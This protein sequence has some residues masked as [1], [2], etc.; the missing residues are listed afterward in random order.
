MCGRGVEAEPAADRVGCQSERREV[1]RRDV[2]RDAEPLSGLG[3]RSVEPP[4]KPECFVVRGEKPCEAALLQPGLERDASEVA[5]AVLRPGEVAPKGGSHRFVQ[6]VEPPAAGLDVQVKSA[7]RVGRQ[8]AAERETVAAQHGLILLACGVER[9][10]EGEPSR[11]YPECRRGGDP[12]LLPAA[13]AP[14][15]DAPGDG[16]PAL[17]CRVGK[18]RTEEVHLPERTVEPHRELRAARV[19]QLFGGSVG[20]QVE[21]PGRGDAQMQAADVGKGPGELQRCA[22]PLVAQHGAVE[23]GNK[24]C[25]V[26]HPDIGRQVGRQRGVRGQGE[27]ARPGFHIG[28]EA[29]LRGGD[30]QA[31]ELRAVGGEGERSA[32]LLDG[33]SRPFGETH[34]ADLYGQLRPVR[35]ERVDFGVET[36]NGDGRRVESRCGA[37]VRNGILCAVVVQFDPV[38]ADLPRSGSRSV[39]G[40]RGGSG[41]AAGLRRRTFGRRARFVLCVVPGRRHE[42]GVGSSVE[43]NRADRNG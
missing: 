39:G 13:V 3:E 33:E 4:C 28:P 20:L 38:D 32:Q 29:R 35:T 10:R 31:G 26:T 30:L 17:Q 8:E 25:G 2:A 37:V 6:R 11:A 5:P 41:R 43:T 12:P 21:V 36:R 22:D 23:A 42:A 16:D 9:S 18:Q 19:E 40:L 15:R 7:E 1:E 34:A 14:E 24:P 27:D